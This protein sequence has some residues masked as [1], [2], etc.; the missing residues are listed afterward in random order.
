MKRNRG[1]TL[2]ELLVVIG[3]IAVL[4][5]VLLP[6]LGKARYQ[7]QLVACQS[8]LRQIGIATIMYANDNHDQL[9]PHF[10]EYGTNAYSLTTGINYATYSV[11]DNG[12]Y[13]ATNPSTWDPGAN[14]NCLM[15]KGYLGP[16][17]VAANNINWN[18]ASIYPVR[19]DPG[20]TP[21]QFGNL[22]TGGTITNGATYWYNCHFAPTTTAGISASWFRKLKNFN[23][24]M[25]LAMCNA[26][27][28]STMAHTRSNRVIINVLFK[29]GHIGQA[30]DAVMSSPLSMGQ[31]LAAGSQLDVINKGWRAMEDSQDI[32]A[33][34]A[35][36]RDP[37]TS[38]AD[39]KMGKA[40]KTFPLLNRLSPS[41]GTLHPTVNW[42]Y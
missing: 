6:A 17:A 1:F 21:A 31:F 9:P 3:I 36:G 13:S 26:F 8:N 27:Q 39:P 28:L 11:F 32:A 19:I 4:I 38:L 10:R 42:N 33:T 16:K 12:A 29:D 35:Q 30:V 7:A 18:D 22:G 23:P 15:M 37:Q 24:N 25:T 34:L 41:S 20:L 2:V 40:P 14:L 5:S